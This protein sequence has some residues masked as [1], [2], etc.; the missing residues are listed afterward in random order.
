MPAG[1]F[2]HSPNPVHQSDDRILDPTAPEALIYS[3]T[4]DGRLVLVGVLFKRPRG[5]SGPDLG[6]PITHWHYHAPCIDGM[7]KKARPWR[8]PAPRAPR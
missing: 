4:K 8:R 6:G 3:Q 1:K 2:I 5:Y 7:G